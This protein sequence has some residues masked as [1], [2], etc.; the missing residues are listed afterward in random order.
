MKISKVKV[1]NYRLLKDFELDLEDDLSVVIGKNNCGKTSLLSILDQF[2]GKRSN[3]NSFSYN[4]F[5]IEFQEKFEKLI[6]S[7]EV[8]NESDLGIAVTVFIEYS[9]LDNLSNLS[10]LMMDLDPKNNTVVIK[11]E[12][13]TTEEELLKIRSDF[14]K[15]KKEKKNKNVNDF[16][17]TNHKK[18]FKIY[19]KAICYDYITCNENEDNYIDLTKDNALLDKIIN[20][21]FISAKRNIS[22]NDSDNALSVLSSKYYEKKEDGL[23]NSASIQKFKNTL[24]D[25]DSH[26]T[27][28]Y[29][30]LFADV[31]KKV[32][33]FGGV[34]KDESVIKISSTLQHKELLKGNTTVMYNHSSGYSLPEN[35]N[36]LGYLN[37]ITM[38]F[39]IE[40]LLSEFRMES[41]ENQAPADINLLF[42]EEPEAHTHPQM[43]YV[44]IK[45]IK[46][47]LKEASTGKG[48]NKFNLQTIITTHSCQ[49]TSESKFDD[50]K[51]FYKS[52]INQVNSKNLKDLEKE[53]IKDGSIQSFKFLKQYLTLHRTELFFVDKA[54]FIEGDTERILLPA[55]MKKI[56]QQFPD[57][58]LLSQNI[59]IVEV[60]AHS[61][62]FEK[63][64]DFI[65]MKSLIITDFDSAKKV[66]VEDNKTELEK[67]PVNE[68]HTI[69]NN[70][71][72]Y[73]FSSTYKKY[74]ELQ[75]EIAITA[76]LDKTSID[77]INER[78]F[79][80]NLSLDDKKLCKDISQ[81]EWISNKN[82]HV[83]VIYQVTEKNSDGVEYC[84]RSFED[85]F[86]HLNQQFI[87]DNISSFTSLK[88]KKDFKA[89]TNPY[90]LAERCIEKKPNFAMEILINSQENNNIEF[91]NWEIP[92]YIKEG[93]LWLKDK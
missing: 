54:I 7:T 21:K 72:K 76:E 25:T 67:C 88:N 73:F 83:L 63:F 53:Y 87:L 64:I 90:I 24:S 46:E 78:D 57:N 1:K 84:A 22:N 62:V 3:G 5:N 36:G 75:K 69:T 35:Y 6:E 56:D 39:E 23:S 52:N 2:I 15:E 79:Y 93:L 91:S 9:R 58:P 65:G 40:L 66:N 19:K 44:F 70:S 8:I 34:Q 48:K 31:I 71:L 47:I 43:Q 13:T 28:I 55:M 14:K 12:Y 59:S 85:S 41:K 27:K 37:L 26:L 17:K 61:H 60:G 82:G 68:A 74:K 89:G 10:K 77:S 81:K 92:Y 38:I 29:D 33:K 18:Y 4:D 51:Y 45:N 32:K 80:L 16:L 42:I 20:F 11:F 86:F 49:I 30:V 50:I